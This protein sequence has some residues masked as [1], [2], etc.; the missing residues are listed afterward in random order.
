MVCELSDPLLLEEAAMSTKEVTR[1]ALQ[2]YK[3]IFVLHR[4]KLPPAMKA[5]GDMYVRKEFKMHMYKGNCSRTQ[6]EQFI[7]AWKSYAEMI[8]SQETV[9]GKPLSAEQ[10]RLL[11]DSQRGQLEELE[12]ATSELVSPKK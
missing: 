8:R 3:E 12:K 9:T 7:N 11:N 6:F 5:L 1:R 2:L 10:R 4:I